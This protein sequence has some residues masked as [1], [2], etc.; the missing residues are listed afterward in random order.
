M[1]PIR[2]TSLVL[3][4]A[5]ISFGC[6]ASRPMKYYTLDVPLAPLETVS[7]QFPVS[8]LVA[9]VAS[10]HLYRDDRVVFGVSSVELGTYEYQRWAEPPVDMI[11]DDLISSLRSSKQFRSVSAVASNLRGDYLIRARLDSLDEVDKPQLAGRFALQLDLYDPKTGAVVWSDS[12]SHDEPVSG[13]K[14]ED[15]VLALDQ[16]VKAGLDQ[17]SSNLGQYFATHQTSK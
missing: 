13:K 9:R 1:R 6:G 12:Y 8:L 3:L 16:N 11:Q 17:L 4:A 7:P 5:G 10:S 2:Q 15:V 14:V